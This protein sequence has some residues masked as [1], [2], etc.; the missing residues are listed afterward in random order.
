MHKLKLI[1]HKINLTLLAILLT[2]TTVIGSSMSAPS[3]SATSQFSQCALNDIVANGQYFDS[4]AQQATCSNSSSITLLGSDDAQKAFNYF[5]SQGLPPFQAAGIVGNMQA[6]SG[7]QPERLQNTPSGTQTPSGTLSQDQLTSGNLGWGIVQWTPPNKMIGPTTKVGKNPDDLSVQLDF[8]WQQLT[9]GT[10]QRA[11]NALKLTT[12]VDDA[13]V[14]F[15]TDYERPKNPAAS[16]QIRIVFAEQILKEYGNGAPSGTTSSTTSDCTSSQ[17]NSTTGY[18]NPFRDVP[19]LK[20]N[21][22]DQGVDYNGSGPVYAIGDGNVVDVNANSGWPGNGQKTGGTFISYQLTDG[23]ASG[24][25]VYFAEDCAPAITS[26]TKKVTADTVICNMYN[27]P[28][29]IETGWAQPGLVE[30]AMA[31]NEYSEGLAT[32]FGQNFSAFLKSLNALPGNISD[33]SGV[34]SVPLPAGWP[35]WGSGN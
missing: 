24:K 7:V 28:T 29:A 3:A 30:R 32:S 11:G 35:T 21:R 31:F 25:Y 34:S 5:V 15:L 26:S 6:E 13:A 18:K 17:L 10:E 19:D 4:C 9:T 8:L 2:I 1:T 12:N 22:I 27:G 16:Q 33:S 20:P 14:S 23:P